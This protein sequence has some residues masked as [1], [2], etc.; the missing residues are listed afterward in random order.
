[1]AADLPTA[2]L[3]AP[4]PNAQALNDHDGR[5]LLIVRSVDRSFTNT[6]NPLPWAYKSDCRDGIRTSS[7]PV[8][9][10]SLGNLA[11][12]RA[13]QPSHDILQKLP[14]GTC[15]ESCC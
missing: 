13:V 4:P 1:M 7:N 14:I 9:T 8:M 11:L 3:A 5:P 2:N 6:A 12:V 15:S 10:G